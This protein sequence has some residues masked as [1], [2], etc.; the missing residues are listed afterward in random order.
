[1]TEKSNFDQENKLNNRDVTIMGW[2]AFPTVICNPNSAL[3]ELDL[4]GNPINH[5]VVVSF[6][7]ALANNNSW[8]IELL[9]VMTVENISSNVCAAFTHT[10]CNCSSILCTNHP[11]HSLE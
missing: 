10:L 9:L 1:M 11:N 5:H 7:D 8:L 2:E 3:E 4:L 6:A